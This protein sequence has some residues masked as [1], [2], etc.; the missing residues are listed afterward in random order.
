MTRIFH[1]LFVWKWIPFQAVTSMSCIYFSPKDSTLQYKTCV[2]LWNNFVFS[3]HVLF[4]IQHNIF[5]ALKKC[6]VGNRKLKTNFEEKK[7]RHLQLTIRCYSL[8]LYSKFFLIYDIDKKHQIV[9][10]QRDRSFPLEFWT[11]N[12]SGHSCLWKLRLIPINS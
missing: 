10:S 5:N 7:V 12:F 9:S 2:H 8:I 11:K 6:F 1:R 3:C 4:R